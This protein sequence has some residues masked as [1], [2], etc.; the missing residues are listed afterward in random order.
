MLKLKFDKETR[1]HWSMKTNEEILHIFNILTIHYDI[2][3]R[4][5]KYGP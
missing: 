3:E 1:I 4:F 2:N 5:V